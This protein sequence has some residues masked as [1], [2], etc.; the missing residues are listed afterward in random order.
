MG[1]GAT[2]SSMTS[3]SNYAHGATKMAFLG[4]ESSQLETSCWTYN[5]RHSTFSWQALTS[6]TNVS[7]DTSAAMTPCC[8]GLSR[9]PAHRTLLRVEA[10]EMVAN[11][12]QASLLSRIWLC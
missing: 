8:L 3:R 7:Q 4:G 6:S 2:L 5:S 11:C 12:I 10:S 1:S 9:R